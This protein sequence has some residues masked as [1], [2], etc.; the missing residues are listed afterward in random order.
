MFILTITYKLGM[1]LQPSQT[2]GCIL[3]HNCTA[4]SPKDSKSA[5]SRI[6]CPHAVRYPNYS[7]NNP[8]LLLQM[9]TYLAFYL[10]DWSEIHKCHLIINGI[11]KVSKAKAPVPPNILLER[12]IDSNLPPSNI[13]Q[14]KNFTNE[15]LNNSQEGTRFNKDLLSNNT[16]NVTIVN[17][18]LLSNTTQGIAR[19]AERLFSSARISEKVFNANTLPKPRR[20]I[21]SFPEKDRN[22][23]TTTSHKHSNATQ[24]GK[25]H[26]IDNY[27]TKLQEKDR[28]SNNEKDNREKPNTNTILTI[29]MDQ[30]EEITTLLDDDNDDDSEYTSDTSDDLH[31]VVRKR[32]SVDITSLLHPCPGNNIL[33]V[34]MKPAEESQAWQFLS[35]CMKVTHFSTKALVTQGSGTIKKALTRTRPLYFS[36]NGNAQRL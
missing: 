21:K 11:E 13:D 15:S 3:L 2:S 16:N 32:L 18:T 19:V 36:K 9:G 26:S 27:P 33:V 25:M 8:G 14:E 34:L 23:Y 22:A 28:K 6:T 10:K 29:N 30:S 7:N 24:N 5:R 17:E 20:I 1:L 12:I 4:T 31:K 35:A